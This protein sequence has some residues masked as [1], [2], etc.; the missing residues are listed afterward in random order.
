MINDSAQIELLTTVPLD[1]LDET[2]DFIR[3]LG[4][5]SVLQVVD[6]LVSLERGF[7]QDWTHAH[8]R[9]LPWWTADST[10]LSR[11]EHGRWITFIG[12]FHN[13]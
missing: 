6:V 12:G 7:G 10:T 3:W 2:Y 13:V 8:R 9:R 11:H 4:S 1:D 5:R